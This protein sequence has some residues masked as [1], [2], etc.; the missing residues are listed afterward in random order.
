MPLSTHNLCLH[1]LTEVSS[2]LVVTSCYSIA[3]LREEKPAFIT[4][5]KKDKRHKL[6]GITSPHSNHF[7]LTQAHVIRTFKISSTSKSNWDLNA[8]F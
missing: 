2:L 3:S 7:Y 8:T 1:E 6:T 4:S 5:K